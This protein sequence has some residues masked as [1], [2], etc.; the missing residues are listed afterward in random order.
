MLIPTALMS[1]ILLYCWVSVQDYGGLVAF[2]VVYGYVGAGV[3]SLFP[4]TLASL[5]DDLSKMGTRVGMVFTIYGIA[6]LTGSPICGAL[7]SSSGGDYLPA[8]IFAGTVII[9]GSLLLLAARQAKLGKT[10]FKR[11]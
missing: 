2:A 4:A 7:V 8:Q 10:L 1:G 11:I 5:T 3:Q 9:G 6:V